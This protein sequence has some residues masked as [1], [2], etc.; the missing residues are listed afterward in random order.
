[1]G[2]SNEMNSQTPFATLLTKANDWELCDA[3]FCKISDLYDNRMDV[4]IYKPEERVVMLVWHSGGLIGNGGFDYLFSADFRGDPGFRL[5]AQAFKEIGLT[6]SYEA[7]ESAFGLF[8][9]GTM[10][11]DLDERSAAWEKVD[12]GKRWSLNEMVWQ[13]DREKETERRL[14][15]YIRSHAKAFGHLK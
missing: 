14:A 15:N 7:F 12:S 2:C 11:V 6:R 4:S 10:P 8:P 9:G 1:M 13:D 5:T 3:T